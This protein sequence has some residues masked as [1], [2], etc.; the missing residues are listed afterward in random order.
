MSEKYIDG[1]ID[2]IIGIFTITILFGKFAGDFIAYI[3]TQQ[4]GMLLGYGIGL[5]LSTVLLIVWP[6]IEP[7]DPPLEE[8]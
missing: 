2:K 6:K 3:L 7:D 1:R 8:D 5:M 4:F